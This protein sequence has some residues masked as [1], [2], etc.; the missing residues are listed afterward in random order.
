MLGIDDPFVLL[1]YLG[2][3]VMAGVCVVYGVVRRNAAAGDVTP[4]VRAGAIDDKRVEDETA[5]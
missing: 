5:V 3:I 1:A 4:E 2:C